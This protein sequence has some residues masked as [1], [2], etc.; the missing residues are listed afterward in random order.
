[1]LVFSIVYDLV[2]MRIQ[3]GF[4]KKISS[5]GI[6]VEIESNGVNYG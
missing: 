2:D 4:F 1:M 5:D 3:R 6:Q